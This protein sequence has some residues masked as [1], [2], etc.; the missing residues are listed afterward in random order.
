MPVIN[1][2][3][4]GGIKGEKGNPNPEPQVVNKFHSRSDKDSA[5]TAQHHT[6]GL[7]KNQS[8]SGAHIHDGKTARLL[9]DGQNLVLTGKLSPTTVAEVDAV[10]DSLISLLTNFVT[11]TD[12]RT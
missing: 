12:A 11:F 2:D 1:N 5:L 3:P 10:L 6:L 7:A 8:S 9:G 4:F